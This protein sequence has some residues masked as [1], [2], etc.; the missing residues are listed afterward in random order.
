MK[1]MLKAEQFKFRNSCAL[2][3]IIGVIFASCFISVIMGTYNSAEQT[4]LNITKDSMVLILAC[5]IYG[6]IILTDD[7][8]NGLLLHYIASGYRRTSIL[9][10]KLIHYIL[11][12]S[13]LLLVYPCLCVSLAA[14]LHG[15]ETTFLLVFQEMILAFFKTLPLYLGIWGLF[16]F[17]AILIKKGV[18]V[19]GISVAVSILL[20]VFTNRLYGNGI[21]TLKYSPIIQISEAVT[22]KVTVIYFMSV[23]LSLVVL[24]VCILG[25][26]VK[27]NKDEL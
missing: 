21:S 8:S 23:L 24:V 1:G 11:G 6:A 4:L 27:F 20:V 13:I 25:S 9:F 26:I 17:F 12:C 3:I 7:F 5:A 10:A 14:I 18:A 16:F 19:M 2:W 15:T 22:G